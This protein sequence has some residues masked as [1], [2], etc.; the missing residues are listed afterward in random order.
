MATIDL[1]P[2]R[3]AYVHHGSLAVERALDP[4]FR[5]AE[6]YLRRDTVMSRT[7]DELEH[8]RS[9]LF[10]RG[11][12]HNDDHFDPQARTVDWDPYSALRTT[13]GGRQSPALGLGHELV[14]ADEDP[15]TR[16]RLAT[17]WSLQYDNAEERRVIR[18]AETH[19]ARTLGEAVRADHGGSTYRVASPTSLF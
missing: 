11:N 12:A 10:V 8:G 16:A 14:H 6:T 5:R 9:G 15:R 17:T 3:D 7:L 2:S 18:G 4:A 1:A 19:A 13:S